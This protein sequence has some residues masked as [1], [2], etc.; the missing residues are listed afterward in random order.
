MSDSSYIART[1]HKIYLDAEQLIFWE[2]EGYGLS[3]KKIEIRFA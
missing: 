1:I 3:I 2:G